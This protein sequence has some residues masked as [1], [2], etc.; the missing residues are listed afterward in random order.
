M[1]IDPNLVITKLDGEAYKTKKEA[2]SPPEDMTLGS[3]IEM[4]LSASFADDKPDKSTWIDDLSLGEK[5]HDAE[6]YVEVGQ[7]DCDR[8]KSLVVKLSGMLPKLR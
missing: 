4:A 6:R 8:L 5:F 2:D 3:V 1:F 7:K